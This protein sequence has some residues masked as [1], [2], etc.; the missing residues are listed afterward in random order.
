[1]SECRTLDG[2]CACGHAE[3]YHLFL[4]PCQCSV[5]GCTCQGFMRLDT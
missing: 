5:E 1:M 3:G 4:E 2:L